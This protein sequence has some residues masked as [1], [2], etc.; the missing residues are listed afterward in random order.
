MYPELVLICHRPACYRQRGMVHRLAQIFSV[1]ICA[2][3]ANIHFSITCTN[4]PN[5]A[6]DPFSVSINTLIFCSF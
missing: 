4:P 6:L 5:P 2:S 3:A 1:K